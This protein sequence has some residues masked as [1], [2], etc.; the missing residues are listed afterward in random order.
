MHTSVICQPVGFLFGAVC[1]HMHTFMVH[2]SLCHFSLC[3]PAPQ[4]LFDGLT[5]KTTLCA[6]STG[7][8][9][10]GMISIPQNDDIK[11]GLQCAGKVGGFCKELMEA[12]M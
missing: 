5:E 10:D 7:R 11:H 12:K 4:D 3:D 9:L 6:T 8:Y 2:W 1:V